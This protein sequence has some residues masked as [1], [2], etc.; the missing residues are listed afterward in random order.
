MLVCSQLRQDGIEA[1]GNKPLKS[2]REIKADKA[3]PKLLTPTQCVMDR[4]AAYYYWKD[5]QAFE[6]AILVTK[7]HKVNFKEIQEW[8]EQEDKQDECSMFKESCK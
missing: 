5:R 4:L 2:F 3:Y 1:V 8:S 6:Q 7:S